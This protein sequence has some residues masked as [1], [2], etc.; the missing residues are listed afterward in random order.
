MVK[1]S[2][3]NKPKVV[4]SKTR[5]GRGYH[6]Y[7]FYSHGSP[8]K[9]NSSLFWKTKED[10]AKKYD[11]TF[12]RFGESEGESRDDHVKQAVSIF[13]TVFSVLDN[14]IDLVIYLSDRLISL[15]N[16]IPKQISAAYC[17]LVSQLLQ[18]DFAR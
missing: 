8:H 7:D 3:P 14:N 1:N 2:D 6:K 4:Y 17:A 18:T 13:K 15:G 16:S 9:R 12:E 5:K 10:F 11:V